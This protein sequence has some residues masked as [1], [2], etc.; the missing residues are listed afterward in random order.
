MVDVIKQCG[1]MLLLLI[2]ANKLCTFRYEKIAISKTI[3]EIATRDLSCLGEYNMYMEHAL[4]TRLVFIWKRLIVNTSLSPTEIESLLNRWVTDSCYDPDRRIDGTVR[5]VNSDFNIICQ[6]EKE[7]WKYW[8]SEVAL[9]Q[10]AR[11]LRFNDYVNLEALD[12]MYYETIK[13]YK[14]VVR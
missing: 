5:K 8:T 1:L 7:P 12:A 10:A 11:V 9:P 4:G 2:I 13:Q 14:E 6:D 3:K